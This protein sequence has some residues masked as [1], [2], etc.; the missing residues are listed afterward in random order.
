MKE[1]RDSLSRGDVPRLS[2][3][4][5]GNDHTVGTKSDARTPR[6]M[7]ADNDLALGRLVEEISRS[8]IWK[9]SAIFVLEDDA[10]NGPDHV[11]AHRTVA[12]VI[13]PYTRTSGVDST[14]Y[15]TTSMLRT[16]E[17]ILGLTPMTNA[18]ADAAGDAE[19]RVVPHRPS[20]IPLYEMNPPGA[21]MQEES[22][23]WDFSREDAAPDL[24]L[25][26]AVWKSVKGAEASMPPPVNAAFVR[27]P[28]PAEADDDD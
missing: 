22:N 10:Q 25:N 13:S 23:C 19:V 12:F 14:L 1:F 16:M 7:V 24:A 3:I 11:D 21:P 2:I 27:A 9:E 18:F 6:A 5:L 15:S 4:R 20:S 17:L 26:E 8:P 28:A